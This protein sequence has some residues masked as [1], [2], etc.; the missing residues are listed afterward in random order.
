MVV[1]PD[2]NGGE[3]R[4]AVCAGNP[5]SVLVVQ[6]RGAESKQRLI[7]RRWYLAGTSV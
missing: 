1:K 2:E 4:I 6:Y 3:R 5:F 7:H